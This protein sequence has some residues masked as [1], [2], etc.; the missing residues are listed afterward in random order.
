MASIDIFIFNDFLLNTT[1]KKIISYVAHE[2]GIHNVNYCCPPHKK[3]KLF[4]IF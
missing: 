3:K 1:E 4:L 2:N